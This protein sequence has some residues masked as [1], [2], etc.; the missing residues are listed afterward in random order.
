MSTTSWQETLRRWLREN[1][2]DTRDSEGPEGRVY[3]VPF[4]RVW[5]ELTAYI[6]GRRRWRLTHKDEELGMLTVT[7]RS[8]VFRFVDDLT[9]WVGLDENGQT[10]VEARSA[11]RVGKG[12]FGV[13]RRRIGRLLEHLDEVLGPEARLRERRGGA[14]ASGGGRS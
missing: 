4:A 2:A 8:L 7:C 5:D 3:T 6:R 13:N 14:R 9:V 12:D 10:R 1:V 11:S